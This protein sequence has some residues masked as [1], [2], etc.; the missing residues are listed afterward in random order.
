VLAAV[1]V[2]ELGQHPP[3]LQELLPEGQELAW[4]DQPP[5][6]AS[7][8]A[9]TPKGVSR[10]CRIPADA[11]AARKRIAFAAYMF[12]KLLMVFR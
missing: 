4:S 8:M 9:M 10:V 6:V 11:V 12:A 1:Q 3:A 7:R 2:R 5:V